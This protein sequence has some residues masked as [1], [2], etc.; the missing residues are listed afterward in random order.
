MDRIRNPFSPGA[1]SPPPELVGRDGILEDARVLFARTLAGK[2]EKSILLGQWAKP[3]ELEQSFGV[4]FGVPCQGREDGEPR[5]DQ[6]ERKLAL[7]H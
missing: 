4:R 7:L 5:A 6:H 1:G 3:R 2:P